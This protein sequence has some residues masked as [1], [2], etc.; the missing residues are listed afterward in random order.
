MDN[1][2][3]DLETLDNVP[4]SAILSIGAVK[5]DDT[6]TDEDEFYVNIDPRTCTKAGLTISPDTVMWWMQQSDSARKA[7]NNKDALSLQA[8]LN[9]FTAWLGGANQVWG[10][11]ATFDNPILANAYRA[12]G[13]EPPWKFWND[14]CH[15]TL[16]NLYPWVKAP[17]MG[18]AHNALDDA[19][20]QAQHASAILA[21]IKGATYGS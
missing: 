7:F 5:F 4:T 9:K 18:T 21:T 14:R 20:N 11:G 10:N 17:A 16:K 15:R 1:A 6:G 3:V 12:V 19:R 2:M 13:I 8:A